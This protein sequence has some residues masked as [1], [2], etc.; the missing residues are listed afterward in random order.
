LFQRSSAT[1]LRKRLP[2]SFDPELKDQIT[3][4]IAW[5]DRLAHRY[6][7][8]HARTGGPPRFDPLLFVELWKLSK[9]FQEMSLKLN[10]LM[11]ARLAEMPRA[12]APKPVREVVDALAR[13]IMFGEEFKP[14]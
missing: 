9:P 6:L 8:E 4:L 11:L 12:E 3:K 2:D 5:R 13:T 1:A 7:I 10:E 14:G